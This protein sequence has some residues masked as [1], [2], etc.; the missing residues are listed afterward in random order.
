MVYLF[1]KIYIY[2]Y[3]KINRFIDKDKDKEILNIQMIK[4][5][6]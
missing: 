2:I 5:K 6:I 3:M 4:F 1:Y